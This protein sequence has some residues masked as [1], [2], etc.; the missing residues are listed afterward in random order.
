MQNLRRASQFLVFLVFVFL[1]LNTEYKDNDVLPYA[2]N[3]FLRLDPLV[4][5]A[6]VLA[7]RA[8][9]TLVWPALIVVGLTLI[10]GRFF[11]GWF[12]PLGSVLD[13]TSA[14]VFRKLRRKTAVPE[15]WRRAKYLLLAFLF[16]SSL[17]TLQFVFL[18]D[19][20]SIII[21]SFT[22][23]VYPAMN[24]V[25]N[26]TLG[27]LYSTPVAPVTEPVYGFLQ[28]HFLAFEQP[29][30]RMAGLIG[31]IFFGILAAEYFQ[32]RFWCRNLCPL[33]AMLG[34][35]GRSGLV[36]RRM[37]E[38]DCISCGRCERD[39]RMGAVEKDFFTTGRADCI[40]CMDCRA[41]CPEDAISF[42]GSVAAKGSALDL[43]RRGVLTSL[44]I[45]AA[46]V[47]LFGSEAY[48]KSADPALIRPPGALPED[49]FLARCTRC[50]ECMRVCI[51][52]GLQPSLFEAGLPGL[53][54]PVLAPRIGYCEYNC[55]LCGQVCP[56]G[57][58]KRLPLE[59]KKKVKLGLA[60]VD[61]DH[62]LPWKGDSECIVC[63]EHCPTDKKAIRLRD[64]TVVT[65]DGETR[66]FKRPYVDEGL[67]VGCGICETKCPLT[68]RS[69]IFVTSRGESRADAPMLM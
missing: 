67:C 55:T 22:A 63:E 51:A 16:A 54:S 6:A 14:A 65:K 59:E 50:G 15:S 17:F 42:T 41:V 11:C 7:G 35:L 4:A 48:R 23:A 34:L 26:A 52:N 57:A 53:W 32:R 29:H 19:P 2:V 38:P 61:R 60:E 45:G 39:C 46:A 20:I 43:S 8:V 9:I 30:F 69:A 44:A 49:E 31:F 27:P 47:P 62:C 64:E 66:S 1:F 68:D 58:I 40:D 12:C 18:L 33:G 37:S 28:R 10:L 56:T 21:R 25:I 36:K 13:F 5:V 3:I 24:Y